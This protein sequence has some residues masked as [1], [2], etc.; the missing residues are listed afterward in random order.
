MSEETQG[1]H[2]LPIRLVVTDDLERSRVTV[3]FRLLL[4][5][6]HLIVLLLWGIAA[7]AVAVVLWIA[8]LVE[9]KAPRAL[10]EFEAGYLRYAAQVSAYVYL[11][12]GP[13]PSFGGATGYPIDLELDL[14]ARQSRS[15]VAARLV[16]AIPA[17]LLAVVLGGMGGGN[18]ASL[19]SSS[20]GSDDWWLNAWSVG[21][22]ASTAA[23][24]AWFA[25]LA[26]GRMPL[27]LRDLLAYCIGYTAQATGY[28]LL[29]TD[30]YPTTDPSRIVPLVDLPPHPVRLDLTDDVRR[31]RMTVFFRFPL[32][33]PHLIWL[34]LWSVL[35]LVLTIP[36]W[37]ATLVIGR[38]PFPLHRFFTAWIRY[39]THVIAFLY[40]V[41]GPFP[42]FTG[43]SGSYPVD[44]AFDRAQPQRRAIT[45]F[46][47]ILVIPALV[48]SGAYG[49]A[50]LVAGV[51][52]WWASLFTGRMP[53]GL[54]NL[55]A[56]S[57]RYSAQ[58]SAYAFL[59]TDM[60]AYA[61]PALRDRP[62]D[63]QLALALDPPGSEPAAIE[64]V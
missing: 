60:Y 25:I 45:A 63:V 38:L 56:V 33:V 47:L 37:L 51:L 48:L 14:A 34:T 21:G 50:A 11:A 44:I 40:V 23:V 49:S 53:E 39:T 6:P 1:E 36:A 27:G 52:G 18:S 35:V 30:R 54:R 24:L 7:F 28:L 55:G 57:L 32:A 20:S 12:A 59:V 64:A 9:G 29:V 16:L 8:L 2:P 61:A 42:G 46:R 62:R 26:R 41:G 13:Y 31:S 58:A 3:L 15:G 17:L 10:Q 43:R 22:V 5:L 19:T 4:A